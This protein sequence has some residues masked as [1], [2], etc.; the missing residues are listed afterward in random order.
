MEHRL[1][2]LL[3]KQDELW[4]MDRETFI[5]FMLNVS[6]Y[7]KVCDW[8][9]EPNYEEIRYADIS[10]DEL[11]TAC[12]FFGRYFSDSETMLLAPVQMKRSVVKRGATFRIY[13][14]EQKDERR[15]FRSIIMEKI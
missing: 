6:N 5:R 10:Y 2:L 9:A 13:I 7:Y 14:C 1:L 11:K 4:R 8:C 3:N 15:I 12:L